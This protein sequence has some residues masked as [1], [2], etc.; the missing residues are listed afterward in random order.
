MLDFGKV[1]QQRRPGVAKTESLEVAPV[2]SRPHSSTAVLQ[3]SCW[4]APA[5]PSRRQEER[6]RQAA[7]G[8]LLNHRKVFNALQFFQF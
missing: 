4:G 8:G 5:V 1:A 7:V 6:R 2:Q 3:E